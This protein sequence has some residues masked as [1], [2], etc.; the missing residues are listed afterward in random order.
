MNNL[1]VYFAENVE[2]RVRNLM[3]KAKS[4]IDYKTLHSDYMTVRNNTILNVILCIAIVP[5]QRANSSEESSLRKSSK[6]FETS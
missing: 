1:E 3:A 5:Y 2:V 4:Q 6:Y